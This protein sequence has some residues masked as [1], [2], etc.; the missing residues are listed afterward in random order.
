MQLALRSGLRFP[1]GYGFGAAG[2]TDDPGYYFDL[3]FGK[4]YRPFAVKMDWHAWF[5][6]LAD[7]IEKLP[8]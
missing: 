7:R 5:L 8:G 6:F 3:S 1:S 2:Y 4:N